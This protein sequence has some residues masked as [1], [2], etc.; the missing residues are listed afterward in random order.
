MLETE[1]SLYYLIKHIEENIH[2]LP[3][4]KN[5]LEKQRTRSKK[6]KED[7]TGKI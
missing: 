4:Q 2:Q 1:K 6:K 5:Y 7:L 3:C